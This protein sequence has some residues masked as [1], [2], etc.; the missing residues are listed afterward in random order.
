MPAKYPQNTCTTPSKN[1]QRAR[2]G[3]CKR[4]VR[5]LAR[6]GFTPDSR[7]VFAPPKLIR[8]R[9]LMALLSRAVP[10]AWKGLAPGLVCVQDAAAQNT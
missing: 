6:N 1:H 3:I 5:M 2:F 10:H 7:Q 9:Y 4:F 8:R